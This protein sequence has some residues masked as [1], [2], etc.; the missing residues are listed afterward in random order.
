MPADSG[1]LAPDENGTAC[2][3]D[4]YLR[5]TGDGGR[6]LRGDLALTATHPTRPTVGGLSAATRSLSA[7]GRRQGRDSL[8]RR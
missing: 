3:S 6:M 4:Y 1:L 8:R 7:R 5:L 2:S